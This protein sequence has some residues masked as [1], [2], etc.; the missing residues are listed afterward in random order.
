MSLRTTLR[1]VAKFPFRAVGLKVSRRGRE[2]DGWRFADLSPEDRETVRAVMPY[3]LTSAEAVC[4][5]ADAVRHV[6]AHGVEGDIVECG[7]W[8]GG[9]MA[10]AARTLAA[11]KKS[12]R[13]LY[14]F[15]TF[16][17]MPAPGARDVNFMGERAADLYRKRNGRGAGS[18]W[19]RA[20]QEEVERVMSSCGYD[21][22]LIR[23]VKGRVEETVPA[24]APER[25]SILR[26]DMDWY[27]PTRHALE[28]L[29]PRLSR[30]GLLIID[31]YGHWRGARQAADEYLARQTPGLY[32]HRVDYTV[33]C[34]VKM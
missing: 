24:Q 33:R 4:A 5:L 34:A 3:T 14:L 29:F 11:L 9:S 16:D 27:E 6:V 32:L 8:R 18:D 20:A 30:G 1:G 10:A 13:R 26:L 2:L 31:D 21:A 12:D 15:D 7:V 25:V 23:L 19:N 17:G 22:A 28:H